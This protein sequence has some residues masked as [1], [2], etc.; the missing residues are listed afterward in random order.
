MG[1]F[2]K[3]LHEIEPRT[4]ADILPGDGP[5]IVHGDYAHYNCLLDRDGAK[6]L[7]VVDWEVA[8][9]GD[10][11]TDLAWC[12]MQFRNKFPEQTWAL[13]SLFEAYGRTPDWDLRQEA[14]IAR[15]EELK[16]GT[17]V[18][19]RE[20][21]VEAWAKLL[22]KAEG[23]AILRAERIL[24]WRHTGFNVHSLVW[25]KT[26]PGAER[27]GKYMIRPLLAL[28]RLSF[29]EPEGKVGYHWGLIWSLSPG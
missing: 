11:I 27:V 8:Y 4:V 12:E 13:P 21:A 25:T 10:P 28:E 26:K 2:L 6:L 23:L 18:A 3:Q 7:A 5:V 15:L 1:R 16:R 19:G 24:S 17:E 29:L 14:M 20:D 22:R 9:L